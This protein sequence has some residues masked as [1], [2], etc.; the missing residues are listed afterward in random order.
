MS[1]K[2]KAKTES[3]DRAVNARFPSDLFIQLE[4]QAEAENRSVSNMLREI[5]AAYFLM[6]RGA[7]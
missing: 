1:P 3:P 7:K 2:R 4:K 5:V 6:K